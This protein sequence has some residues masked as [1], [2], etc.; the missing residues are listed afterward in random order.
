M[1]NRIFFLLRVW[2]VFIIAG[3]LST[4]PVTKSAESASGDEGSQFFIEN[5]R[6]GKYLS[7]II[8]SRKTR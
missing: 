3:F 7:S 2:S 4:P 6:Y 8:Y 5:L 1:K